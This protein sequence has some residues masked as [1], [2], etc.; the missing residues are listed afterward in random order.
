VVNAYFVSP[1]CR[2]SI[3]SFA[4]NQ[5]SQRALDLTL[6]SSGVRV[7]QAKRPSNGGPTPVLGGRN[8]VCW[9]TALLGTCRHACGRPIVLYGDSI[10]LGNKPEGGFSSRVQAAAETAYLAQGL[11]CNTTRGR[12]IRTKTLAASLSSSTALSSVQASRRACVF[13]P[14]SVQTLRAR[15]YTRGLRWRA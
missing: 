7:N 15:A 11:G 4:Q 12:G 1:D 6:R 2:F 3:T 5:H 10:R 8:T 9:R 13:T 14:A